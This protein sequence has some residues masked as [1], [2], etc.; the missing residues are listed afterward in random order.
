[1]ALTKSATG[2][3]DPVHAAP[4]ARIEYFKVYATVAS[5]NSTYAIFVCTPSDSLLLLLRSREPEVALVQLVERA[6]APPSVAES[7]RSQA[8]FRI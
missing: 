4:S 2:R 1:M 8:I 3:G 5:S 6:T 7:A